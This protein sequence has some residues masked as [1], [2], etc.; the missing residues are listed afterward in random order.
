M[1]RA[2]V[3]RLVEAFFR[4]WPLYL[5][6]LVASVALGIAF[7]GRSADQYE[8]G[9]AISVES[10][11]L[12]T[13]QSGIRLNANYSYLT[14]A[15]FTTQEI[16]GLLATDVFMQSVLERADV[17]V[18]TEVSARE[19]QLLDYRSTL[20]VFPSSG[21]I[22]Q[23]GAVTADPQLSA[24]LTTALIDEFID[25]HIGLDI[26]ESGASVEFFAE[27]VDQYE[28]DVEAA[29]REVDSALVGKDDVE[30]L[31]VSEQLR[32]ERLKAA[33]AEAVTRYQTAINNL[34]TARL[35]ELQTN[36]DVEQSYIVLDLP[37]VPTE[38]TGRLLN[39]LMDLAMFG[40]VGLLAALTAPLVAAL[41][42]DRVMFPEDI[43]INT[44]LTVT[45]TVP[46]VRKRLLDLRRA[47]D[48]GPPEEHTAS[49]APTDRTEDDRPTADGSFLSQLQRTPT[50]MRGN[51]PE[52]GSTQKKATTLDDRTLVATPSQSGDGTTETTKS[53]EID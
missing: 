20:F 28:E 31:T 30:E 50:A 2:A 23:L 26:A 5:L 43:E 4:R 38:P 39:D 36:T 13:T 51:G 12:V 14:P 18:A 35:A 7:V 19:A 37:Q 6:L 21:N 32:I 52:N 8:S 33:E 1:S 16:L 41:V 42:S 44:G 48:D 24:N 9:A 27:L 11:S 34:E 29:R 17:E 15:Q 22:V 40:A 3:I 53:T 49:L 25:Y 45:A 46:R 10:Q 47:A